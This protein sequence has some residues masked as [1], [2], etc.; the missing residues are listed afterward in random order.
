[1]NKNWLK[2]LIEL[3]MKVLDRENN[4]DN[5]YNKAIAEILKKIDG[6]K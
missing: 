6:T 4:Q 3:V 5:I 2:R 1:M